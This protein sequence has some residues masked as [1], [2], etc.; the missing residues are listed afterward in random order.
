M[1][2]EI[3]LEGY[4]FEKKNDNILEEGFIFNKN[5]NKP[6]SVWM[7]ENS[8]AEKLIL[9]LA[10]SFKDFLDKKTN[11]ECCEIKNKGLIPI[12]VNL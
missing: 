7:T 4:V 8:Q 10:H 3:L 9:K 5:K 1:K 6:K 12:V 11:S 2:N